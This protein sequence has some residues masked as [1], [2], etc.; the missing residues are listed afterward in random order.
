MSDDAII[1]HILKFV[2]QLDGDVG[3]DAVLRMAINHHW[4][5]Q[6]GRPTP[7]GRNLIES[8]DTLQRIGRPDA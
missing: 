7:D 6:N 4:L 8:M 2:R 3:D 5:D 1:R